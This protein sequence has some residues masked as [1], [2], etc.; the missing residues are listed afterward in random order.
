MGANTVFHA[1]LGYVDDVLRLKAIV[2]VMILHFCA[3]FCGIYILHFRKA[4]F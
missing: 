2:K 4:H 1:K 3:S